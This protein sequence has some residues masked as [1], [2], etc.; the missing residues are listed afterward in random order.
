[1][2]FLIFNKFQLKKEEPTSWVKFFHV[3]IP[4]AAARLRFAREPGYGLQK[5]EPTSWV[6]LEA[7]QMTE[8]ENSIITCIF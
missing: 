3:R 2:L 4:V 7:L 5:E 8:K 1:M 6:E